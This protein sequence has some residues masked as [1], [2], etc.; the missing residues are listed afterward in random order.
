M[1]PAPLPPHLSEALA[2]WGFEPSRC[3]VEPVTSGWIN[4]TLLLR[5]TSGDPL[6]LQRLAPIFA[7]PVNLDLEVVTLHLLSKGVSTPTLVRTRDDHPW[8]IDPDQHCWR[9]LTYVPGTTI[10][11]LST[12]ALADAAGAMVARFHRCLDGFAYEFLHQRVGVH[13]TPRHLAKLRAALERHRS[14]RMYDAVAPVGEDILAHSDALAPL[15]T[16]PSRVGHGDLKVTNLRFSED[17]SRVVALLDLD[18]L[19]RFPL[20]VEM[21][22]A[23]RSWCNPAGEA[24]PESRCD[25]AVFASALEG[26]ARE[27]QGFVLPAERDAIVGGVETIAV[28]LASRFAA[29]ALEESYFGWDTARYASRSEHNLARAKAQLGLARSVADQRTALEAAVRM[30]FS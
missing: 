16:E 30:A 3:A 14:H 9:S 7:P 26:Y 21:G 22:D 5:P 18:T 4:R 2:Q 23:L 6:V 19:G 24:H 8:W 15:P 28:E 12:P 1:D 25:P 27:A 17:L 20:A 29:D 10:A 11:E 13:D